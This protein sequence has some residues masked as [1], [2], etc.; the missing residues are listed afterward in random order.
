MDLTIWGFGRS[1]A[2]GGL[3]RSAGN[4]VSARQHGKQPRMAGAWVRH[5]STLDLLRKLPR[6]TAEHDVLRATA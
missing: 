4:P 3:R 5:G 2:P 1:L 6:P